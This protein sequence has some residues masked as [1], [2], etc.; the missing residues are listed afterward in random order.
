MEVRAQEA[1]KRQAMQALRVE[2]RAHPRLCTYQAQIHLM[3]RLMRATCSAAYRNITRSSR[4]LACVRGVRGVW[5]WFEH[6]RCCVVWSD[7]KQWR[8]LQSVPG[9]RH[10]SALPYPAHP[11]CL[12]PVVWIRLMLGMPTCVL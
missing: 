9:L 2:P 8:Q 3:M 7:T 4:D 1:P 12:D 11:L 6:R 5:A 10:Q